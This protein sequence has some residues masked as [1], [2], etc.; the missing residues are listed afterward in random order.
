ML[1]EEGARYDRVD[2]LHRIHAALTIAEGAL[3]RF[4]PGAVDFDTKSTRGDPLTA[5][6]LA[7]NKALLA[8]LPRDG[9]GWL[10]EET[11][12]DLERLKR[13]RVWIVDPIDGTREFVDGI[14]EWC[15]SVALVEDGEL[16]AGGVLNP[17][18]GERV[19]G[20]V[21]TGVELSGR[22]AAVSGRKNLAGARV[23]ASRSEIKRGDWRRFEDADFKVVPCGSVA[24]KQ[25]KL[26]QP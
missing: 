20:S 8:H 19:V 4:T 13:K 11:A 17:I 22:A 15:I 9:E 23:L 25:L 5:A 14:P 1:A 7:V 2:D 26:S 6:D 21:E 24:Y 3:A 12:D 10:S 18:T 16:V